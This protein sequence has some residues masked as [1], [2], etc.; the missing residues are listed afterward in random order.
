MLQTTLLN[1]FM[2]C[3]SCCKADN[4]NTPEDPCPFIVVSHLLLSP[5]KTDV[6]EG[7]SKTYATRR[8]FIRMQKPSHP[9]LLPKV[10]LRSKELNMK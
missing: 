2:D 5:H 4:C 6:E 10:V 9:F 8:R 1:K 3:N 7:N